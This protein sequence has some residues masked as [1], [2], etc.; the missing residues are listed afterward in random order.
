MPAPLVTHHGKAAVLMIDNVDTDQIIPSREM[1]TVSRDGLAEGL[2]AG[3]RYTAPGGRE[4]NPDFVLNK[5][6]KAGASILISGENFGCGSSREHAV[7]ALVEYGIRVIIA[8]SF[9]EIF[10]GNCLRNGIL[11]IV[12]KGPD[13]PADA[14][15]DGVETMTVH[16]SAQTVSRT[17]KP[18]WTGTFDIGNYPKQLLMKGLDPIALTL[19]DK[20]VIEAFFTRDVER[21]PWL[22]SAA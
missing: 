6:E 19:Q 5:P 8:K 17:D 4:P 18:D 15:W 10:H 7:W 13:I 16:L 9:G 3:W 12:L 22:Y 20:A 1:K 2:F 21:R 11:P 14:W